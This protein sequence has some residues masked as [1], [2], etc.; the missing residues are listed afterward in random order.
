[1]LGAI[2]DDTVKVRRSLMVACIFFVSVSSTIQGPVSVPGFGPDFKIDPVNLKV[3][4]A[5]LISY[6]PFR[7]VVALFLDVT[8]RSRELAAKAISDERNR[9][10]EQHE[11]EKTLPPDLH[12]AIADLEETARV[13]RKLVQRATR[14]AQAF[15]ERVF[16]YAV[17]LALSVYVMSLK[18]GWM[19]FVVGYR[20]AF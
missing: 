2:S 12:E 20:A 19:F 11:Y 13:E 5:I 1:M 17:P 4:L 15:F 10:L 14:I 7:L 6:L 3:G 9:I 8:V 16:G 18:D